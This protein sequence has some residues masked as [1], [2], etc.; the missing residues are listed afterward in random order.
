M[1]FRGVG[2]EKSVL[3]NSKL[4]CISKEISRSS[5]NLEK[6]FSERKIT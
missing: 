2:D 3:E 5:L 1:S 6:T 4:C